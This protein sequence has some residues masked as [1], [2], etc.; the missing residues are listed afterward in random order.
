MYTVGC[1]HGVDRV[2]KKR[3]VGLAEQGCGRKAQYSPN[4]VRPTIYAHAT[5]PQRHSVDKH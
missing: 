4:R 5:L 3:R 1:C 2:V